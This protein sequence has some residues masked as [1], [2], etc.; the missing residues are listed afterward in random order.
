MEARGVELLFTTVCLFLTFCYFSADYKGF[1]MRA[2]SQ[3][4]FPQGF[5][6]EFVTFVHSEFA[7]KDTHIFDEVVN[8]ACLV[9]SIERFTAYFLP[10]YFVHSWMGF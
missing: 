1:L 10:R 2:L 3:N 8:P 7:A 6:Q 9:N 5:W 4:G